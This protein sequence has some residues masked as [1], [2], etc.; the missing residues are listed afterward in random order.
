VIIVIILT[1]ILLNRDDDDSTKTAT[2][3]TPSQTDTGSATDTESAT[4]SA[5]GAAPTASGAMAFTKGETCHSKNLAGGNSDAL[6]EFEID[7]PDGTKVGVTFESNTQD[8]PLV[9]DGIVKGKKLLV[10]VPVVAIGEELTLLG[11]EVPGQKVTPADV[12]EKP[13]PLH[14]VPAKTD[15]GPTNSCDLDAAETAAN[16]T[17]NQPNAANTASPN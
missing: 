3:N 13:T 14:E 11:L 17:L 15:T 9:S 10:R 5:T 7:V 12:T 6:F 1:V 2:V 16:G 4:D 8:S